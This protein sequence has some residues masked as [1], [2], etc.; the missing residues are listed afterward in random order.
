MNISTVGDEKTARTNPASALQRAENLSV[1]GAR[2]V[3]LELC[4]GPSL[5]TLEEAYK[6]F[7]FSCIGNDIDPR[8]KRQYQEGDWLIGN[9]LEIPWD[10][11][12]SLVDT[13][14]VF[15]PP[16]SKGCT[17]K[18]EDSLRPDQVTPSYR[19]FLNEFNRRKHKGIAALVLPGRAWNH[20]RR[21]LH[22]IIIMAAKACAAYRGVE[23]VP[24]YDERKR[25]VKYVDVY[26]NV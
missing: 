20:N 23:V 21:E 14:V 10:G 17:G 6:K 11:K 22:Q 16:L 5:R 4:A 12:K 19:E 8:W 15:A 9:C 2:G 13:T 26:I 3:V 24:L 7:G 1:L 25:V 18:R